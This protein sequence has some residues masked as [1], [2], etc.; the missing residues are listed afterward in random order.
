MATIGKTKRH[1]TKLNP[2]KTGPFTILEKIGPVDYKLELPISAR[3]GINE[4][5]SR[6]DLSRL[7]E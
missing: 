7:W 3:A 4:M 6:H 1:R 2:R 5:T